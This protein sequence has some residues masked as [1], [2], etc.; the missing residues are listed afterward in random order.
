MKKNVATIK[1]RVVVCCVRVHR[2]CWWA[3][4]GRALFF[5]ILVVWGS[6]LRLN[7]REVILLMRKT[8]N[9]GTR[10]RRLGP[11]FYF[12]WIYIICKWCFPLKWK[13]WSDVFQSVHVIKMAFSIHSTR[14]MLRILFCKGEFFAVTLRKPLASIMTLW[15]FWNHFHGCFVSLAF[16]TEEF[17]GKEFSMTWRSGDPW[18]WSLSFYNQDHQINL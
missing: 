12:Q 4:N 13:R 11:V 14:P 10:R 5:M 8:I 17:S 1:R 7:C 6:E 2:G 9:W 16:C 15:S 3:P 18:I